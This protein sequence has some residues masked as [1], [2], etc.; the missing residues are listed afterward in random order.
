MGGIHRWPE[1]LI[2]NGQW[3]WHRQHFHVMTPS[4]SCCPTDQQQLI[5]N[6]RTWNTY[7][8]HRWWWVITTDNLTRRLSRTR[9]PAFWDTHRRPM[10]THTRDSHPIPSQNKTKSKLQI[11]K[12]ANNNVIYQVMNLPDASDGQIIMNYHLS[13]NNFHHRNKNVPLINVIMQNN[14]MGLMKCFLT[15]IYQITINI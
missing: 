11:L 13:S 15:S 1:D 5:I 3:H 10:I 12:I 4:W 6:L 9:T 14:L 7:L 8:G 2:I